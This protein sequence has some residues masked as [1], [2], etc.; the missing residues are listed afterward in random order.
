MR[1]ILIFLFFSLNIFAENESVVLFINSVN[2]KLSISNLSNIK[3]GVEEL[4]TKNRIY[5]IDEKIQN[6][7]L[8]EQSEQRKKSCYDDSCL[9]DVG[10]MVSA[11]KIIKIEITKGNRSYIFNT[12]IIDLEKGIKEVSQKDIFDDDI[13]NEKKLSEF[14]DSFSLRLIKNKNH[15]QQKMENQKNIQENTKSPYNMIKILT[16]KLYVDIYEVTNEEYEKCVNAGF[17]EK[18]HYDDNSCWVYEGDELIQKNPPLIFQ[19]KNKPV[20]CVDYYQAKKYCEWQKK[21]LPTDDELIFIVLNEKNVLN[22]NFFDEIA[23]YS[24]NSEYITHPVGAKKPNT[25]G[26]YDIN[27]NVWEWSSS[28]KNS[29]ERHKVLV[30]GAFNTHKEYLSDNNN[31]TFNLPIAITYIYGFRCVKED[32]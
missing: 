9:I 8:K 25:Y 21:R 13:N 2:F 26:V 29:E 19:N 22:S 4:L 10:K 7:V 18:Q 1:F 30:G 24:D 23:W 31:K 12:S 6:E 3:G 16:K 32:N 14:I 5:L 20:V 17:C 15:P 11:K 27:G 28:W